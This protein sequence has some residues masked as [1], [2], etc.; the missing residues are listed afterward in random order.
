MTRYQ[1]HKYKHGV[2]WS[3]WHLQWVTKYRRRIFDDP[4]LQKLCLVFLHE[5]A[6]RYGFTIEEV[7]VDT[8]HVHVIVR[9]RPSMSPAR[10]TQLLKGYSSRLLFLAA[11]NKLHRFYWNDQK[12]RSVWGAGK[13]MASVGH[14][15][16][17]AAKEYVRSHHA[18]VIAS[19]T[20]NPHHLW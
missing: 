2:G 1:D 16:L 17:E 10:A 14:I 20:G 12:F 7:E 11:E 13:F 19:H 18:K 15:T 9:L 4:E 3:I 5:T 8:D 6:K